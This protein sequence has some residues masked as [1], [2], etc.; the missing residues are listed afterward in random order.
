[1]LKNHSSAN[2]YASYIGRIGALAVA[3]GIGGAVAGFGGTAWADDGTNRGDTDSGEQREHADSADPSGAGAAGASEQPDSGTTDT[4]PQ[5]RKLDRPRLHLQRVIVRSSGGLLDSR[6]QTTLRPEPSEDTQ[7]RRSQRRQKNAPESTLRSK[8]LPQHVTSHVATEV[9]R[10]VENVTR[11]VDAVTRS[12]PSVSPKTVTSPVRQKTNLFVA[13]LPNP[14][15]ST[16]ALNAAPTRAPATVKVQPMPQLMSGLLAGVRLDTNTTNAPAPV[17]QIVLG[18]LQL[19][20]REIEHTF[21][22]RAPDL[23]DTPISLTVNQGLSKTI[24]MPATDSDGDTITYTVAARGEP[25]GPVHGTVTVVGNAITY[26]PDAD[27]APDP[28]STVGDDS[29]TITAS[30]AG[31]GFHLHGL[32]SL[33]NR[34]AHDDT[35]QVV[36]DVNNAPQISLETDHYANNFVKFTPQISDGEGD[37]ARI[38]SVEIPPGSGLLVADPDTGQYTY[39]PSDEVRPVQP[40]PQNIGTIPVTV[41]YDDGFGNVTTTTVTLEYSMVK[42]FTVPFTFEP[43]VVTP[44]LTPVTYQFTVK[45]NA[46]NTI[47]DSGYVTLTWSTL[48]QAPTLN[49]DLFSGLIPSL[50]DT[51]ESDVTIEVVSPHQSIVIYKNVPVEKLTQSNTIFDIL[52]YTTT[53]T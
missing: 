15:A 53:T 14:T 42:V 37:P 43:I 20:R 28:T 45:D 29:F 35:G 40:P 1:M 17:S 22:N 50:E 46:G 39:F 52:N 5:S 21:F 9:R 19:I 12:L 8:Q 48:D 33:F 23:P 32:Q 4:T 36:V 27:Y 16:T 13:P 18:A 10:V 11:D 6:H 34:T 2:T 30:D 3:L 26:T 7:V 25:G 44:S 47:G 41:T 49:S 31:N 38:L 51:T 24:T